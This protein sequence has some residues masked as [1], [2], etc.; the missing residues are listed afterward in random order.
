MASALAPVA[1]RWC[2]LSPA[3]RCCDEL[4]QAFSFLSLGELVHA[5]ATCSAWLTAAKNADIAP[6]TMNNPSFGPA[7]GLL[8]W[9]PVSSPFRR[10]VHA[11]THNANGAASGWVRVQDR[12]VWSIRGLAELGK[13]PQLRRISGLLII[14]AFAGHRKPAGA[15]CAAFSFSPLLE[16]VDLSFKHDEPLRGASSADSGSAELRCVLRALRPCHS[17]TELSL[18]LRDS[19]DLV[20]DGLLELSS[21]QALTI[22]I[23]RDGDLCWHLGLFTEAQIGVVKQLASLRRLTLI[24]CED[25]D[26]DEEGTLATRWLRWLCALPHRLQQLQELDLCQHCLWP[27]AAATAGPDGAEAALHVHGCHAIAPRFRSA[28]AASRAPHQHRRQ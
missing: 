23:E 15:G 10:H 26:P 19:S 12:R 9:L 24:E 16:S 14:T 8:H 11:I 5:A 25:L 13:M 3:Q 7:S 18:T 27:A 17:L 20:L 22:N 6:A 28:S 4:A 21:L 1:L 2:D